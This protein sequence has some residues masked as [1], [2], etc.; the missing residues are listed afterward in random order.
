MDIHRFEQLSAAYGADVRRWPQAE[1]EAAASLMA[2]QPD[3]TSAILREADSLDGLLHASRP[4]VPSAFL[5]EAVIRSA[6]R[7]HARSLAD[8]WSRLWL[9]GAAAAACAAGILAGAILVGALGAETRGEEAIAA[10]APDEA[11]IISTWLEGRS[12]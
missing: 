6:R 8:A 2:G 5:R 1:R 7:S 11:S 9:P 4:P 10:A 3:A 12:T